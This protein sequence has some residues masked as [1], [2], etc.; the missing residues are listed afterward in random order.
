MKRMKFALFASNRRNRLSILFDKNVLSKM[1]WSLSKKFGMATDSDQVYNVPIN[2][3]EKEII[4][5]VTLHASFV[6]A[7]Q[8]VWFIFRRYG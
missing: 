3:N 7:F 8:Q 5:D 2:P 6:I 4:L 1:R